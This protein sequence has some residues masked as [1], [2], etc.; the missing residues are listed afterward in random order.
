[1]NRVL[2]SKYCTV[3]VSSVLVYVLVVMMIQNVIEGRKSLFI[4][5]CMLGKLGALIFLIIDFQIC[6]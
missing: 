2:N 1:M 5:I 3:I 6:E 4:S